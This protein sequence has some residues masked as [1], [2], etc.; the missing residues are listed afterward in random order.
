VRTRSYHHGN[1]AKALLDAA[2]AMLED[3]S[4]AELT[5]REV[6][7]AVGVAP[8]AAYHHFEDRNAL[9]DALAARALDALA[10]ALD[11]RLARI[12]KAE[13]QRR[14]VTLGR[15]YVAWARHQPHRFEAA[16]GSQQ[17]RPDVPANLRPFEILGSLLD[18]AV[19]RKI[20]S[21]DARRQA[22]FILWPALH[23]L[24]VL[25]SSGPLLEKS[26][27]EVAAFCD[28]MVLT[29]LSGLNAR[30]HPASSHNGDS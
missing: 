7:A 19:L 20:L 9:L 8:S 12:P 23:G 4:F 6:A 21:P 15:A 11:E 17:W 2:D 30:M 18:E 25:A 1:L 5:I 28:D 29:I 16:F 14:L 26:D 13:A 3:H 22:E 27:R 24:A 10:D